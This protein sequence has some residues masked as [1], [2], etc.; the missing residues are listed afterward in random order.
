MTSKLRIDEVDENEQGQLVYGLQGETGY[1]MVTGHGKEKLVASFLEQ[2]GGLTEAQSLEASEAIEVV[3]PRHAV[4]WNKRWKAGQG[5]ARHNRTHGSRDGDH[6]FNGGVKTSKQERKRAKHEKRAR[7]RR[8][9]R[10]GGGA[11]LNL[12][13]VK[14]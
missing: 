1:I 2:E 7:I 11:Y 13:E 3:R 4:E 12:K 14:L 10:K 5:E 8:L 9:K 6:V